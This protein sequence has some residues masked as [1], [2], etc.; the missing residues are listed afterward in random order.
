M[1]CQIYQY[2]FGE[3]VLLDD[4]EEILDMALLGA[5]SIHGESRA[6]LEA[7]H[8]FDAEQGTFVLDAST[9]VGQCLNQLFVGYARQKLG[10]D[11]FQVERVDRLPTP[12]PAGAAV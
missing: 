11:A 1:I 5:Q 3:S 2:T 12:E 10:E 4:V 6:R 8:S 9:P 7:R